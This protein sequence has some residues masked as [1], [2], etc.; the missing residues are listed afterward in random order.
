MANKTIIIGTRGSL[1]ARAQSQWVAD[2]LCAL[3][4]NLRV[5]LRVIKT[6]GDRIVDRPLSALGGKG[7]F[8]SALEE[9][10]REDQ[11]DLA[12]HS[13]KDMPA[14][15]ADDLAVAAV[16]LREDVR[17]ALVAGSARSFDELPPGARV[18]TSSLR[19]RGQLLMHRPDLQLTEMHGNIDT[20]IR[21]VLSGACD[22]TILAL[23]GLKRA[24]LVDH[25]VSILP[26]GRML[27]SPGQGALALQVNPARTQTAKL[28]GGI[29]H[30]PS[31]RAV[32][33]ERELVR[34]LAGNC[35][36]PIAALACPDERARLSMKA[37]VVHP[38]GQCW[39]RA[40]AAVTSGDPVELACEVARKLDERGALALLQ[41]LTATDNS[42]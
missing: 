37:L 24:G 34:A 26:I 33:A 1:L 35:Q 40:Q 12:V 25:A 4:Q 5:E 15:L 28:L 32:T 16:P 18:A 23:A 8:T 2:Q 13:M 10:L 20:R 22:A 19:R 29:D 11:I 17:D 31:R 6:A 38:D 14:V 41:S 42:E 27:P 30:E 3:D 39:V 7:L 21:K 9:A 36:A